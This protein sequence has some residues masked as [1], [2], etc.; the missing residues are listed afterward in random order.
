MRNR[1][2]FD[3]TAQNHCDP[4][5]GHIPG[6]RN[7][8]IETILECRSAV[9]VRALVGVAGRNRD[10]R[11]LPRRHALGV[12]GRRPAG[13]GVRRAELRRILARVVAR[14]VAAS[15]A[16]G[17]RRLEE[18]R[19]QPP[20]VV[21]P[22]LDPL[23]GGSR[24]TPPP[25]PAARPSPR[26]SRH[27]PSG[28]SPRRGTG[29]PTRAPRRGT[30]AGRRRCARAPCR[31]RGRRR[32]SCATGTP[33]FSRGSTP[34]TGSSAPAGVSSTSNQPISGSRAGPTSAS[35]ARA[36]ICPP[37]HTPITGTSP[38]SASRRKSSS[39]PSQPNCSSWSGCIEPPKTITAPYERGGCGAPP[40]GTTQRSSSCPDASATSSK[41]PPGT[42][43]PCVIES[44]RIGLDSNGALCMDRRCLFTL[45]VPG[46]VNARN[47]TEA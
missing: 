31:P 43:G 37:R 13:G 5:H 36:S 3:G 14:R 24:G 23:L 30:P 7:L 32:C 18:R 17:V 2:E 11:L 1:L 20:A 27:A 29:G 40:S 39:R 33:P 25:G 38:A 8:S 21:V 16:L 35:A 4:R 34:R 26:P 15:G 28:G 10:R 6:A 47:V 46:T 44:T 9:A 22:A 41:I 12:R 19:R 45:P 42:L